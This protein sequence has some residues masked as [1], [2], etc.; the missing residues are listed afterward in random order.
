MSSVIIKMAENFLFQ[1]GPQKTLEQPQGQAVN[2]APFYHVT[3]YITVLPDA[4]NYIPTAGMVK[5]KFCTAAS[6]MDPQ[7]GLTNTVGLGSTGM[8]NIGYRF[9]EV[10][11]YEVQITDTFTPP[12]PLPGAPNTAT[13]A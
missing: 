13:H 7:E 1:V 4:A 2:I 9:V 10:T 3:P 11:G 12:Q 8:T 6:L 5:F